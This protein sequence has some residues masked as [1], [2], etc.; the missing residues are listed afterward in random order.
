[1]AFAEQSVVRTLPADYSYTTEDYQFLSR[2]LRA[3][4]RYRTRAKC[5]VS[6]QPSFRTV[7]LSEADLYELVKEAGRLDGALA[8]SAEALTVSKLLRV[9]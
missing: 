2:M 6:C 3:D 5:C 4:F 7:G 8:E 9:L 1:M